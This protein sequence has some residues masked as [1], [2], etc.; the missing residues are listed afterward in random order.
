M[1]NDAR[2]QKKSKYT[3][4]SKKEIANPY[5]VIEELFDFAHLPDVREMM[6]DWMKTTIAGGFHKSLNSSERYAMITLYEKL[7][8]LTEAVHIL[9]ERNHSNKQSIKKIDAHLGT[10]AQKK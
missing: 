2:T 10:K 7:Y 1:L 6:W 4:L 9:N 3:Q 5:L 8:K